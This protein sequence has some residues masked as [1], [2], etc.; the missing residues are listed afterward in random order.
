M[1]QDLLIP[2]YLDT[3][4][5]LDLIA[6]IEGGFTVVEKVTS[7]TAASTSTSQNADASGATEFGTPN[8]LNM[9]KL[10][11][12]LGFSGTRE[13]SSDEQSYSEREKYHTYGSLFH[14]LRQYLIE[15]NQIK[16]L[17]GNEAGWDDVQPSDFIE[18]HGT[19]LPNPLASSFEHMLRM[20][21]FAEIADLP[22]H[23]DSQ[24]NTSGNKS[25]R[26]AKKK[27]PNQSANLLNQVRDIM[28]EMLD[29]LE[30]GQTRAFVV[31]I[32]DV[33]PVEEG[34]LR[35]V[36]VLY[37]DYLRDKTL[38]EISHKQYYMLGKVMRKIEKD[39]GEHVDLLKGA[40]FEVLP[41]EVMQSLIVPLMSA[42]ELRLPKIE[43]KIEGPVVEI[44]PIAV[45]V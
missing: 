9:L 33:K 20:L 29:D 7:Q 18:V 43:T 6:A 41:D 2:V 27:S 22:V 31:E 21:T 14:R 35:A 30:R 5:L 13:K 12:N 25:R 16:F 23:L 3:N 36:S 15:Q 19:F 24:P 44:I 11:V 40:A 17:G 45:F 42:P 39:S 38:Y 26:A 32:D 28:Q 8:F 34:A 37:L 4:V 1:T 10:N